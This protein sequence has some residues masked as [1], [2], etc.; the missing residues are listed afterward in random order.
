[1]KEKEN[2]FSRAPLIPLLFSLLF[3]S[4]AREVRGADP[5]NLW[6]NPNWSFRKIAV[7]P[8]DIST[9]GF[10]AAWISTGGN[11]R[12]DGGDIRVT[13]GTR[14]LVPHRVI[15]CGFGDTALVAFQRRAGERRYAIYFGNPNARSDEPPLEI[16]AGL[17][18]EVLEAGSGE[19][20][21]WD[22]MKDLLQMSTKVLGRDLRK[23]T[24]LG[25]NPYGP[26]KN[27]ITH[28][29]GFLHLPEEGIYTFATNS[30]DA[31]FVLIDGELVASWPGRHEP[32]AW[33]CEMHSGTVNLRKGIHRIDYYNAAFSEGGCSCGIRLPSEKKVRPIPASLIVPL[34]MANVL[35]MERRGETFVPDFDWHFLSD[36]GLEGL[37]ATLVQFVDRTLYGK[38]KVSGRQ[39]I[40]GDGTSARGKKEIE[41]VYLERGEFTVTLEILLESGRKASLSQ[42][43][44]SQPLLSVGWDLDEKLRKYMAIAE[45]YPGKNLSP[46]S[47]FTLASLARFGNDKGLERK[48]L[49]AGFQKKPPLDD[50]EILEEAW[51]YAD[52]LRFEERDYPKVIRHYKYIGQYSPRNLDRALAFLETG[53]VLLF[54]MD[55]PG[56]AARNFQRILKIRRLENHRVG[57]MAR[58]RLA[59]VHLWRGETEEARKI[60]EE[61][62]GEEK[63][64]SGELL[65]GKHLPAFDNYL[66]K[67]EYRAAH[68]E[69]R[70]WELEA[71]LEKLTGRINLYRAELHLAR[72]DHRVALNELKVLLSVNPEG[73]RIPEALLL[74]AICY[75]GLE[76]GGKANEC[77]KRIVEEFP[78]SPEAKKAAVR[79]EK[80]IEAPLPLQR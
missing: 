38:E 50:R 80:K 16:R 72:K 56:E 40:F 67:K 43:V 48:A 69:L 73:N 18:L 44:R 66:Q 2:R 75:E 70:S 5:D 23:R 31:S 53:E 58:I 41:H 37:D 4:F 42:K 64:E 35:G 57:R 78:L 22:E 24:S 46:R 36:L 25:Y 6:W 77:A 74:M 39:W 76:E 15:W 29:S 62:A 55:K 13:A 60:L 12:E 59:D 11:A 28:F 26:Q 61:I 1:M 71:P 49:E 63:G 21:T 45:K 51:A 54:H 47:C 3:S 8:G 27:Y 32:D 14:T 9:E 34:P 19:A 17:V 68:G 7:V 52:W 33:S 65:M 20:R 79:L 10:A 30:R